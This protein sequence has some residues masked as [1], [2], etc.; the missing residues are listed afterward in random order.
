[1]KATRLRDPG[2]GEVYLIECRCLA[3]REGILCEEA[4]SFMR[5]MW[6]KRPWIRFR[7]PQLREDSNR[8]SG[9]E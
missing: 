4:S 3:M 2:I 8:E 9:A 6:E 5:T 7:L 1:M